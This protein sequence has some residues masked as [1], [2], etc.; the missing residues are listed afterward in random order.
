[1]KTAE[2]NWLNG[3]GLDFCQ[4]ELNKFFRRPDECLGR[5]CNYVIKDIRKCVSSFVF[6]FSDYCL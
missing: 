5:F 2:K 6:A 3:R 1:M 4:S